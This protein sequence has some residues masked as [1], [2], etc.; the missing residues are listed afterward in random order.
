MKLHIAEEDKLVKITFDSDIEGLTT[1]SYLEEMKTLYIRVSKPGS[2]V[3][4]CDIE[5]KY[6]R[7]FF[8]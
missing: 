1:G 8:L 6:I 7:I 4:L 2:V 3:V 5:R